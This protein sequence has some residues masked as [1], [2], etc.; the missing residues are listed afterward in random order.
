MDRLKMKLPVLGGILM[1]LAVA[2]FCR[3]L[4]T[5][6][7]GEVPII[8]AL[9]IAGA[10]AGNRM[11]AASVT[12]A[13]ENLQSGESLAM[14]L[15]RSEHFPPAVVEMISVGE[16]SN[17]LDR[18]LPDIADNLEKTTFRR[19]DLFVRLLEPV[20]LLVMAILVLSVVMALLVPVLKSS[21]SI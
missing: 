5:L 1:N 4:G 17:S 6:L 11:L 8:R 13:S 12:G 10:A 7:S 3:V 19:L 14:P 20:M 2:R 16:E 18:V 15:R 21:Q 9:N